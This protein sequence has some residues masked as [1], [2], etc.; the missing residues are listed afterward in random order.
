MFL[1]RNWIKQLVCISSIIASQ[2]FCHGKLMPNRT[3]WIDCSW[4]SNAVNPA[5]RLLPSHGA[6]SYIFFVRL[7]LKQKQIHAF[8]FIPFPQRATKCSKSHRWFA[9]KYFQ[10][11]SKVLRGQH[12]WRTHDTRYKTCAVQHLQVTVSLSYSKAPIEVL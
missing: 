12:G 4:P 7:E 10:K 6:S 9:R 8:T 11:R 2:Q 3:I 5:Q 1:G